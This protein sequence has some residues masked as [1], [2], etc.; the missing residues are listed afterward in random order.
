MLLLD[1]SQQLLRYAAKDRSM[2]HELLPRAGNVSL[3]IEQH[4]ERATDV[5][6][7]ALQTIQTSKCN[8][9]SNCNIWLLNAWNGRADAVFGPL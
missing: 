1:V 4:G 7:L 3:E 8:D 2:L 6:C 9:E 5:G